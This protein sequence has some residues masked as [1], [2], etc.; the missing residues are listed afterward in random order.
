MS[1]EYKNS[2][3]LLSIDDNTEKTLS[4]VNKY[5]AFLDAF[6]TTK[7]GH[8]REAIKEGIRF[9]ITDKYKNTEQ[10]AI[11]TYNKSEKLQNRHPSLKDYL[12]H[13]RIKDQNSFSIDLATGTGK[14]WVIYGVAQ[15]MLAEGLVDKVLVLCPSLTIEEELK[16]KFERFS[17]DAVL[18]KIMTELNAAYPS[19]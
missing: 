3:F 14:S 7:F 5:D 9:F 15:I 1:I 16:K 8:V 13:L 17:G 12:D 4:V 19:Y 10:V 6:T 2:D 18:T 11:Y